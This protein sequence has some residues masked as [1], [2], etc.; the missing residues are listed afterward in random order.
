MPI[1]DIALRKA[2]KGQILRESGLEFRF[3]EDGKAGIRF[4]G[5]VRGSNQRVAISLGRYPGLSLQAARKLGEAHRR[6]CEEGSDP[7]HARQEKA[8]QDQK[9]VGLLLEEYLGTLTDNRPR[10]VADKR[11]T[12][13]TALKGLK[14]RPIRKVTKGDVARLVDTYAQKPA[15]RRKLFSYLSHFLGWCQDRDLIGENVCRQIKAP[16]AVAARERVLSEAEIAALMN[17]EGSLWGTMLKLVLLTGQRGGEVCKM[18]QEELDL[19]AG[20]WTVPSA[21]MKQGRAHA[22]PLSAAAVGILGARLGKLGDGWGPYLFGAGSK[23]TKPYNGRSNGIEE[24]HRLTQTTGWSGH[25][26]R[27]TATTLMQKLGISREVRM[28]VTGHAQPRDGASSYEHYDFEKEAFA[29]VERLAA[30]I[31]RIRRG[32]LPER[33]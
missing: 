28:R 13:Q 4:L 9:L 25:D 18:R 10:T 31:E 8:S 30:E 24:V 2:A 15:A 27:R 6:L 20:I 16:K 21:T 7:R 3:F 11:S 26:C 33:G 17:L 5:R 14:D 19:G 23:G 32:A 1:T 22:V 29:A 12:L